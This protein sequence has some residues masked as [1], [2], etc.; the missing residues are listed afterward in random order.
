M[1]EPSQDLFMLVKWHAKVERTAGNGRFHN[2]ASNSPYGATTLSS[3][4]F[5]CPLPLTHQHAT[6]ARSWALSN[7]P[8]CILRPTVVTL[9][10][11]QSLPA[12]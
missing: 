9:I 4:P 6:Q 5:L 12:S 3:S 2:G 10:T 8:M 1:V 7:H 11:E